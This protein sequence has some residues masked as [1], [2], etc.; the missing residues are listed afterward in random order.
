MINNIAFWRNSRKTIC[1]IGSYLFFIATHKKNEK[2]DIPFL[3]S[4]KKMAVVPLFV[5]SFDFE[6]NRHF[7]TRTSRLYSVLVP[8][9]NSWCR[10]LL[11]L[12]NSF[13]P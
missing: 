11:L 3:F 5:A 7:W 13:H 12:A 4:K 9:F 6:R 10:R 1:V 8:L 2:S